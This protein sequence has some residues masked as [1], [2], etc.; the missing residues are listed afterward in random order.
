VSILRLSCDLSV[1]TVHQPP[2]AREEEVR[3]Q[4][5]GLVRLITRGNHHSLAQPL[6]YFILLGVPINPNN[7]N[8]IVLQQTAH[9]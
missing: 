1:P 5:L 9:P 8:G 4:A 2:Q 3:Y 7:R 6:A